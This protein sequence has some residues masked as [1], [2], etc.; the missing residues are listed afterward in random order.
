M[1]AQIDDIMKN[2]SSLEYA[3]HE[4]I[5]HQFLNPKADNVRIPP[6]NRDWLLDEGLY[7]RFAG[8][9]TVGNTC[10]VAAYYILDN[11]EVR[12]K[13]FETL[14]EAWPDKDIPSSLEVLEKVP[15]LVGNAKMHQIVSILIIHISDC[16][17]EGIFENGPWGCNTFTPYSW[18]SVR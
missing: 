8:S 12:A 15:Y 13:L 1:G 17:V 5:Y 7:M 2:P 16:S 11:E 3:D 14:K 4:T 10:A 6:I 9:D 18:S